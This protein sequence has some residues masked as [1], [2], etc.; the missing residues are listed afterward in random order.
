MKT[1]LITGAAG[2]VGTHLRRELAGRT[3]CGC[4][5]S[6]RSRSVRRG[7][8]SCAP[9]FRSSPIW[10]AP[11]RGWTRSFT[12]ARGRS[13]GPW[14][15]FCVEY[16]R[17]LQRVRGRTPQQRQARRVRL[18]N[19]AVG[20]Y[21]RDADH[22]PSRLAEARQP[23]RRLEG[24]RRAARQSVRREVR[25]CEVCCIRIGNVNPVP[26]DRRRLSIWLSP[27]DLAQLVTIGI[28]HR[29]IRFEIVYG[30]S[31]NH[32]SWYDNS[33]AQR[34]GYRPQ[35][36]SEAYAAEILA[37]HADDA[38][39]L[40]ELYQ[41][42][43][44][45]AAET[46]GDPSRSRPLR[47]R[48][49]QEEPAKKAEGEEEM[50][51]RAP[52]LVVPAGACDTHMHIYERGADRPGWPA[53]ARSL[54]GSDV[55]GPAA[56][57]RP[58]ASDR[59]PAERLSGRQP[60]DNRGDRALGPGAK[61]VG[62]VK[63]GR[64]TATSIGLRGRVSCAAHLPAPRRCGRLRQDGPGHGEGAQVR[65][66]RQHPARRPRPAAIRGADQKPAPAGS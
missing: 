51:E 14:P 8:P 27:R 46:G 20:F 11:P 4:P 57:P 23:L 52:R 55:P 60:R 64:P 35:D 62:V 40:V 66:A 16:H 59:G 1:V 41:G 6:G 54:P 33:N 48:S 29:D 34:L 3:R 10:C 12:S 26:V 17:L 19:H 56:A 13:R 42:G 39:P 38:N 49:P 43:T 2:D 58:R 18:G 32:R 30:V 21:R 37:R 45:V 65:L 63:P 47:R 24:I 61:G 25:A 44:F 22:R 15:R 9:T 53:T 31:G 28:E 7:R 5:T 50:S 36:D